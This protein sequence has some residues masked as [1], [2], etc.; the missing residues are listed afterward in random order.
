MNS[1]TMPSVCYAILIAAI[2]KQ[3]RT[4]TQNTQPPMNSKNLTDLMEGVM[5]TEILTTQKCSEHRVGVKVYYSVKVETSD[6][7]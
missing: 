3:K 2:Y 5:Q 4:R 1:W 6:R 7:H